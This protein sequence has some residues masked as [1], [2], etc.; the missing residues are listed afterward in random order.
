MNI[1]EYQAKHLLLKYDIPVP[2]SEIVWNAD[3]ALAAADKLGGNRW[4]IKAQVHAGGRGMAGGVRLVAGKDELL[5]TVATLI[6]KRLVT[7]Q[8]DAHGQPVNQVLIEEPCNISR[9]LYNQ[10]DKR[11]KRTGVYS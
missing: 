1:H 6:G 3:E 9:E 2:A 11:K 5:Q 4:V 7:Y 8:T 10:K